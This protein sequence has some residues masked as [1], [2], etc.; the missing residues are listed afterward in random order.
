M[1]K[2]LSS[3]V[4]FT[5]LVLYTSEP[6]EHDSPVPSRDIV[7]TGL[8]HGR[9][10]CDRDCEKRRVSNCI[11]RYISER[12]NE[13]VESLRERHSGGLVVVD[14]NEQAKNR[15]LHNCRSCASVRVTDSAARGDS[16]RRRLHCCRAVMNFG[17]DISMTVS[18]CTRVFTA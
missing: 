11:S 2:V 14:L 1:S 13:A 8:E 15:R 6:V 5:Y 18:M 17:V 10:N 16:G 12:T 9:R 3:K 4:Q 7:N